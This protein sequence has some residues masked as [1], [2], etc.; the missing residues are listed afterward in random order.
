MNKL[1][2]RTTLGTRVKIS[3][4]QHAQDV[5]GKNVKYTKIK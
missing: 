5:A 1:K 3:M 2:Q 4:P